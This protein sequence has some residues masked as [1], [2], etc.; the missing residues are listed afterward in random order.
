MTQTLLLS[1]PVLAELGMRY[2]LPANTASFD[3]LGLA[4]VPLQS[5]VTGL[6]AARV[7]SSSGPAPPW[8]K[9]IQ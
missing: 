1:R 4:D 3:A 7:A 5:T 2:D 9:G 6:P 8:P